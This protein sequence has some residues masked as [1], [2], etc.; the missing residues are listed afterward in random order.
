[1][2]ATKRLFVNADKSKIVEEGSADAAFL[3][4]GEGQ[5]IS[6]EDAEKYGLLDVSRETEEKAIESA[7]EN[8][9]VKAP[10]A[11]KKKSK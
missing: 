9:A 5:E 3:L 4:V 2:K 7:P 11:T 1:M 8:K 10:V 6:D